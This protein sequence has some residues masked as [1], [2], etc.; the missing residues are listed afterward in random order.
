MIF[1]EFSYPVINPKEDILE[2]VKF[3]TV[4]TLNSKKKNFLKTLEDYLEKGILEWGDVCRQAYFTKQMT[5]DFMRK[6]VDDIEWWSLLYSKDLSES[7]MRE[8]INYLDWSW[9]MHNKEFFNKNMLR[10][11]KNIAQ[12]DITVKDWESLF[13]KLVLAFDE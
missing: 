10:E 5:E 13:D 3:G 9:V 7:F 2:I 11:F 6:H 1:H 12:F 8:I 4:F